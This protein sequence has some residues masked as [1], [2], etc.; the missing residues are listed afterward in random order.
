[1]SRNSTMDLTTGHPLKQRQIQPCGQTFY[2]LLF[3]ICR[4]PQFST[5]RPL[6]C[7]T[8]TIIQRRRIRHE[9][10]QYPSAVQ[11]PCHADLFL[12]VACF[13][14]ARSS[15]QRV[16]NLS[17]FQRLPLFAG[18]SA[19]FCP[20]VWSCAGACRLGPLYRQYAAFPCHR[21]PHW[22]SATAAAPC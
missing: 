4:L 8:G 6:I 20:A 9:A 13:A 16:D 19:V 14:G 21:A 17:S 15:D 3:F 22:R 5:G 18:R 7:Y 12:S 2:G 11:R 10:Q 1:M